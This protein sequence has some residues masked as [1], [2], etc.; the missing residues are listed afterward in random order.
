MTRT[1][2]FFRYLRL[3]TYIASVNMAAV[4]EELWAEPGEISSDLAAACLVELMVLAQRSDAPP[5]ARTSA[6]HRGDEQPDS[7][8]SSP[9]PSR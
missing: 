2:N 6:D 5:G 7:R 8:R 4:I 9:M 3:P 1:G